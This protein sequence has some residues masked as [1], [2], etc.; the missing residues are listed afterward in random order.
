M[1]YRQLKSIAGQGAFREALRAIVLDRDGRLYAAGDSAVK[2]YA[3]DGA[4][5]RGWKTARPA[6]AVAIAGDGSVYV[7]E[8]GQVEIFDASGKLTDTWSDAERLGLVTAIGFVEDSVLLADARARCIRRYGKDGEFRHNIAKDNRMKG[9]L[10]PN[11]IVDFSVDSAGVIHAT[12]P[13]KHRVERY[14]LDDKLLGHIGHFDGLNPDGFSGC[15]NPT[16]VF[17]AADRVYVTEKA[18]PRAKVFNFAGEL[19][20]VIATEP[21][22]LACKNMDI[23][24]ASRGRVYVVDTVKREVLVFEPAAEGVKS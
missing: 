24:V 20:D 16:N 9:F 12:N 6:H 18:E 21:F 8:P 13:G 23:A 3:P 17:V 22:N 19:V 1:Q 2:V 10:I 14:T 4:P 5:V 15:C 7:G 11:G